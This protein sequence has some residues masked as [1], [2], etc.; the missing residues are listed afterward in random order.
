MAD[1]DSKNDFPFSDVRKM[2]DGQIN[3]FSKIQLKLLLKEAITEA[4]VKPTFD[5]TRLKTLISDAVSDIKRDL[6]L[7]SQRLI[8]EV[9]KNFERKIDCLSNRIAQTE[10][11]LLTDT[12]EELEERQSR[13]K[14]I[15]IFGLPE[16]SCA[17]ERSDSIDKQ[18]FSE[19][20][21]ALNLDEEI[22]SADRC[23]RLG[24]RGS[25]QR[26]LKVILRS[27]DLRDSILKSASKLGK[28]PKGHKFK[29]V[30]LKEDLTRLQQLQQKSLR[31]ELKLRKEAGEEVFLRRG[32]IV[33]HKTS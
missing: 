15:V 16:A 8:T 27:A 4:D 7:E 6:L 12:V 13:K 25:Q 3:K 20:M 30:Y 26:P 31:S 18:R 14:N 17:K 5:E 10:G 2:S 29:E 24:S 1:Q 9:K 33:T 19:L 21:T 32:K 23:F 22:H 11:S 28:L